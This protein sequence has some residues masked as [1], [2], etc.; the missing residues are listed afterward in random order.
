MR[1]FLEDYDAYVKYSSPVYKERQIELRKRSFRSARNIFFL[2]R[3]AK[4]AAMLILPII[5][6]GIG[7]Y[8]FYNSDSRRPIP[9][10]K[11]MAIFTLSNGDVMEMDEK[12]TK[13]Y[14]KNGTEEILPKIEINDYIAQINDFDVANYSTVVV[15]RGGF[16]NVTL[17]DGSKIWLN[18]KSKL[19]F[20]FK[21]SGKE[22]KVWLEGEAYFDVSKD[23]IPFI[24]S[25]E[26]QNVTV[27]GTI[28]N[29]TAY[30]EDSFV[31]TALISGRVKV[32]NFL[33]DSTI[34]LEPGECATYYKESWK[35]D[36]YSD[37]VQLYTLWKEGVFK[38]RDERL[39]DIVKI[40]KRWYYF[41]VQYENEEIKDMRFNVIALKNNPLDNV[42]KL[43]QSTTSFRYNRD[44]SR[45][46]LYR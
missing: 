15:P 23:T 5:V 38:F 13:I 9:P 30:P 27:L 2:K 35:F 25:T 31:T 43:L 41:D 8:L 14:K 28:F 22:R 20:P 37:D 32:Q 21:F 16:F 33:K 6:A 26:N 3:V 45:F 34:F 40:L 18:S 29:I 39:E 4:Y 7:I 46:H 44:G 24:V 36:K 10:G 12:V 42:F 1:Q 19:R 11:E 17:S